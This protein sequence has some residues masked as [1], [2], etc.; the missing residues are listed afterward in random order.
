MKRMRDPEL[1]FA[2]LVVFLGGMVV[3]PLGHLIGHRDDHRHGPTGVIEHADACSVEVE[4]D[5]PSRARRAF[6]HAWERERE[7]RDH[8]AEHA[9]CDGHASSDAPQ[10][11]SAPRKPTDH[12][13]GALQHFGISLL[14]TVDIDFIARERIVAAIISAPDAPHVRVARRHHAPGSARAPPA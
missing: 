2:A 9:R 14:A 10:P 13:A 3:A 12:G 6:T 5:E 7:T 1:G 11:P 4:H 8:A